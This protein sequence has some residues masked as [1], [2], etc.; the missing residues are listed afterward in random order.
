VEDR[1]EKREFEEESKR[2]VSKKQNTVRH[3][4]ACRIDMT[5]SSPAE[6]LIDWRIPKNKIQYFQMYHLL[7]KKRERKCPFHIHLPTFKKAKKS[8]KFGV[9]IQNS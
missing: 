3:S 7:P 2:S 5:A 1:W 6:D 9:K 4:H 8:Q